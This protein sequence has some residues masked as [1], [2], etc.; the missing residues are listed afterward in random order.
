MQTTTS[1][2]QRKQNQ[3]RVTRARRKYNRIIPIVILLI[4][5]FIVNKTNTFEIIFAERN[6]EE[7]AE[8]MANFIVAEYDR[9][10]AEMTEGEKVELKEIIKMAKRLDKTHSLSVTF[11]DD[12][13]NKSFSIF[14][15]LDGGKFIGYKTVCLE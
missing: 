1:R 11:S 9:Q 14:M 7:T 12:D 15:E 8:I 3:K 13:Y 2:V 10:R 4:G 5:L 6:Y